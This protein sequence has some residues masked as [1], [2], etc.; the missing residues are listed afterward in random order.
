MARADITR[1]PFRDDAFDCINCYRVLEFIA[2]DRRAM[3]ELLRVLKPKGNAI[4]Q[5]LLDPDREVTFEPPDPERVFPRND[6]V[7]RIYGRDYQQRLESTGFLAKP[8]RLVM[9]QGD[10]LVTRH[11]LVGDEVVYDC[12]KS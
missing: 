6:P 7:K 1:L 11:G 12:T 3:K 9:E 4:L 5:S 2:D 10:D 8:D